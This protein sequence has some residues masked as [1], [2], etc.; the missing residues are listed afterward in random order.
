MSGYD[1]H[2]HSTASD[3]TTSV[4]R[5]VADAI[6]LGLEGLGVTDH[7]TTAAFDDAVGAAAGTGLELVLGT[8]FS[9]EDRGHSVHLLGYWIDPHNAALITELGRS[10]TS[11]SNW[12]WR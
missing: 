4:A 11:S 1:L 6:G 10:W 12:A 3:G 2:T 9:A 7:D 5:N 8:E